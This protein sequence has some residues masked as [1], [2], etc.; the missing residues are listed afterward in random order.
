MPD[1]VSPGKRSQMMAGIRS[2]DTKPELLVRRGLHARG[3][4]FRIH[5]SGLPGTP[6]IVLARWKAVIFVHGCFW[7]GHN[8]HLFRLPSTRQEFWENKIAR[9]AANDAQVR[10][11]LRVEGWRQ[12]VIW[13]CAIKGKYKLSI[14]DVLSRCVD[15]L[16]SE[17]CFL[18]LRGGERN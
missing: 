2:R 18:E 6:D 3:F 13:E 16:Q 11:S 5:H 12:A 1:I 17:N 14:D 9:N 15:W 8:C 7:H 4:R 10:D